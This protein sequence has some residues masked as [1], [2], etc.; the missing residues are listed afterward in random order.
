V[1]Q[2][3]AARHIVGGTDIVFESKENTKEYSKHLQ[4]DLYVRRAYSKHLQAGLYVR[5]AYSKH[6]QACMSA[7]HKM[8]SRTLSR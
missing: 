6:L 7:V 3:A 4:A 1:G 8:R 2:A 5:R